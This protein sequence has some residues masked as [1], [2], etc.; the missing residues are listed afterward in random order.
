MNNLFKSKIIMI[1]KKYSWL[2]ALALMFGFSSCT[3]LDEK[4]YDRI[5]ASTYYQNE[6]SVQGALAFV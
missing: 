6:T 3:D 1:M 4:V 5:D 2:L